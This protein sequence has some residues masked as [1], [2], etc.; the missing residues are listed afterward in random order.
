MTQL[1]D[2]DPTLGAL[3][4]LSV[5]GLLGFFA[6]APLITTGNHHA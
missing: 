2:D 3:V 4:T 1:Q 6:V 5:A